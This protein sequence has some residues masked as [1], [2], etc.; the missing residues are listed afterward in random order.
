MFI[1]WFIMVIF[2]LLGGLFTPIESM[3]GWAQD[4]TLV[5]PVAYFIKIMRMVLLKGA[6]WQE[7]AWMVAVLFGIASLLML[8]S[9][10]RYKKTAG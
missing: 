5:N 7:I 4:L 1:A 3:P 10:N 2:I 8:L 9:I 6:G